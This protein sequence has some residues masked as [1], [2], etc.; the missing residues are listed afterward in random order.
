MFLPHPMT[1]RNL[2]L[3][4]TCSIIGMSLVLIGVTQEMN[5]QKILDGGE[6]NVQRL[7]MWIGFSLPFLIGSSYWMYYGYYVKLGWVKD[8]RKS[9]NKAS[10]EVKEDKIS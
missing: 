10:D 1:T 6:M 5:P 9:K 4:L 8:P 3:G 2:V 7:M